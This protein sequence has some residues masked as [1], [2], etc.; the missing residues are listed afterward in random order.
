MERKIA[1]LEINTIG[2][3]HRSRLPNRTSEVNS[4][5]SRAFAFSLLNNRIKFL[6]L[7]Q[8]ENLKESLCADAALTKTSSYA[9]F[10][11]KKSSKKN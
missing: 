7:K 5:P 10:V 6:P 1:W 11:K 3:I 9:S 4:P 2:I 8:E